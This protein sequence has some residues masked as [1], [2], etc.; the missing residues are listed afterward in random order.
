MLQSLQR[1]RS[2]RLLLP[3]LAALAGLAVLLGLGTWQMERKRWKEELIARIAARV[4]ADP[5]PLASL[6]VRAHDKGDLEYTHVSVSGRFHH[7]KERYLYAPSPVGLGWHVYSPLETGEGALVW[8]NRGAVPDARKAPATRLEGQAANEVEVRG[9][10]RLPSGP[11]PFAARN[12]P[13]RNVW[14]WPDISAMSASAF[15]GSPQA[16]KVLPFVIDA[17]PQP[18][19]P[20]GLPRGGVTRLNLPNRHLEY[21]LTWY[22]LAAT[23]VGVYLAFA[24]S[25]LRGIA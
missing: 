12:D 5:V 14:Y 20:G 8:I 15:A 19:A 17:D 21:A 9:L 18:E 1:L 25:R 16:A 4:H 3:T 2:A 22:G 11:G 7:D 13:A 10:V 6:P 23:L 24:I